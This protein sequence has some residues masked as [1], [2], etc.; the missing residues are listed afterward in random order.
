MEYSTQNDLK[1]Q[2]ERAT[3]YRGELA[4]SRIPLG[5]TKRKRK[6]RSAPSNNASPKGGESEHSKK[7]TTF[8]TAEEAR[9]V[10]NPNVRV[11]QLL[12]EH[13]REATVPGWDER[14][15]RWFLRME[16]GNQE[17]HRTV[18]FRRY[19]YSQLDKM[20]SKAIHQATSSIKRE[21][22]AVPSFAEDYL[23][24]YLHQIAKFGPKGVFPPFSI[25][26]GDKIDA[27]WS[28]KPVPKS[29]DRRAYAAAL[30][31]VVQL[32]P[33]RRMKGQHPKDTWPKG[34]GDDSTDVRALNT[35]TNSCFATYVHD[36]Y[37]GDWSRTP[38]SED[39]KLVQ[40]ILTEK[41]LELYKFAQ[42]CRSYRELVQHPAFHYVATASQRTV[43]QGHSADDPAYKGIKYSKLRLVIAMPKIDTLLG[44]GI[45]NVM[46]ENLLK[47]RSKNRF[48]TRPFV[49]LSTPES[50]AKNCQC[51]LEL[52]AERKLT[53]LSTDYSAFDAHLA[54][55]FMWD[56]AK[57][58]STW[59][60]PKTANLF[61]ALCY[62]EIYQTCLLSPA[63][64]RKEGPSSMKSGCIFTN[65]LD[66]LCNYACQRLGYHS[67]NWEEPI[68][69]FVQGDDALLLAVGAEPK[70]FEKVA[71]ML[72]L[73]AN[74][75]KQYYRFGSLSFLQEIHVLGYPGGIYPSSRAA[76]ACFSLEDDVPI[77]VDKAEVDAFPWAV[78]YRT[79]SRLDKAC[80]CPLFTWTVE[81]FAKDDKL[82]LGRDLSPDEISARAGSYADKYMG[83]LNLKP[84]KSPGEVV[85]RKG[86]G[87]RPIN[88]VLRGEKIPPPG[89]KRFEWVYQVNYDEVAV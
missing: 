6:P 72:G 24:A 42:T 14:L 76:N 77:E 34:E 83:E 32:F 82:H 87:M 79:L 26:G 64:F 66:S 20:W 54:P 27:V 58:A 62:A 28:D 84:W 1:D 2:V 31:D 69:Q 3:G 65:I 43:Q 81:Q 7:K 48:G 15:T 11:A 44:K 75:D 40:K 39:Q 51:A 73:E 61:L 37:S 25:W 55:W 52:A 71:A 89:R 59:M 38:R 9:A 4:G 63:G 19:S 21:Y 53:V 33:A 50:I 29:L 12:A 85:K 22:S 80:F 8:A 88:R 68:C 46:I 57:A 36:W 23:E 67:G 45:L 86:F 47:V 49:A 30:K 35:D 17:D 78:T 74:A 70:A 16:Q 13:R 60:E 18:M 5:A 56:V 10:V 41:T